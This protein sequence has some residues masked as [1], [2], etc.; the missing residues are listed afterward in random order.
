M[1]RP[2]KPALTV[3]LA[4]LL[5]AAGCGQPPAELT[6]ADILA[7]PGRYEEQTIEIAGEITDASGLFSVG[8]YTLSDGTG[9]LRVMTASGLPTTGT[10]LTVRGTVLSGVTLGGK[11]YG[12]T[13]N[14]TERLYQ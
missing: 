12:V 6:I 14:E 1:E 5:L 4:A 3:L 10:K 9:E 11:H 2:T 13:L 7:D 8:L